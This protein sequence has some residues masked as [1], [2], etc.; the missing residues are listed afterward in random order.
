M[1]DKIDSNVTGAA[2][3]EEISPKVLPGVGGADAVWHTLEP[4]SYSDFG[5]E[6]TTV[7]REPIN[8]SRQRK[9]GSAVDLDASGG[10]TQD[11]TLSNHQRLLR[12]F[13]FADYTSR[14]GSHEIGEAATPVTA[15]DAALNR[16]DAELAG[17]ADADAGMLLLASGFNLAANNGLSQLLSVA[18]GDGIIVSRDLVAEAP[19]AGARIVAVG[20]QF[21]AGDIALDAFA[22]GFT[23]TSTAIANVAALTGLR[24]GA[25]VFVGGDGAGE[26]FATKGYARLKSAAGSVMTFD[27]ATFDPADS[28]GAGITL[29]LFYGRYIRNEDD[30]DLIKAFTYQ[31][32]RTLGRDANGIQSQ[33]LTG[34]YANELTLNIP[35]AEKLTADISY[36]AMNDE[37]R[38]GAQGLKPGTRVKA[39]NEGLINTSSDVYRLHLSILDAS[40]LTPTPLFGYVTEGTLTIANNVSPAK[41]V[42]V[43]GAFDVT[44]GTFEV[45]GSLTA[46]FSTVEAVAAIRNSADVSFDMI[47]AKDNAGFVFDMPLLS[48]GGGRLNVEKDAPVTLPLE[49]AAAENAIGYTLSATFFP[50]LPNSAMPVQ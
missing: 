31:I 29:R 3:A 49:M 44:V 34:A 47:V 8:Q 10:L 48:L 5:G 6:V 14:A 32:E 18:E 22:G 7:A 50:Y 38:T 45:G 28:A 11:F 33:Y 21:G 12:G 13:F 43:F 15:I 19:P 23:L 37:Q 20:H 46:Y 9:K 1:A 16:Y 17:V 27:K 36:V 39:A 41:A 30:P 4:N 26:A 42:G 35:T 25:W 2:I 24:P 40:D